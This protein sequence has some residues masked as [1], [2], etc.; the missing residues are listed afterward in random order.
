MHRACRRAPAERGHHERG[1]QPAQC[2]KPRRAVLLQDHGHAGWPQP[3]DRIHACMKSTKG[4]TERRRKWSTSQVV[5][6][7]TSVV[8]QS[9]GIWRGGLVSLVSER[10]PGLVRL[11]SEVGSG[12]GDRVIRHCLSVT[13]QLTVGVRPMT[14]RGC[15]FRLT[16]QDP[17][18]KFYA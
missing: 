8:V 9:D 11:V 16:L 10:V 3:E 4:S 7:S 14:P 13:G 15:V 18:Q 5:E 12:Q 1:Q 6:R 2:L 17:A